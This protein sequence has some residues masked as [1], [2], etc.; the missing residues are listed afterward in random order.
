MKLAWKH[1]KF[2][3]D[4]EARGYAQGAYLLYDALRRTGGVADSMRLPADPVAHVHFCPPHMFQP[5]VG[6]A[7][8]LYSMWEGD[9]LPDEHVMALA[10]AQAR[11]VPSRYCQAVWQRHGLDS[12]VIPLG[13]HPGWHAADADRDFVWRPDRKLRFLFVGSKQQRKGWERI[14]PAW[15][16]A[17]SSASAPRAELYVKTVGDGTVT[18]AF[19]GD[20][21]ID[22][23]DLELSEMLALYESADAFI[24][25]T[26]GEGFGLPALEAMAAGCLVIAPETGGL[27]EFVS[28]QT[29]LVLER[30]T[31]VTI[32]YGAQY[33]TRIPSDAEIAIK[34][35]MAAEDW[36]TPLIQAIR[37]RGC[38]FA[39]TLTTD[40]QALK[41]RGL[42]EQLRPEPM[43]RPSR[44]IVFRLPRGEESEKTPA[45]GEPDAGGDHAE[46]LAS[47]GDPCDH[48][49]V[50]DVRS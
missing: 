40:A 1:Y 27:T 28:P 48:G 42:L 13:L 9:V 39:R 22:Q 4:G 5:F 24:F 2:P 19:G 18:T 32:A 30:D 10:L 16:R 50:N 12:H 20:V 37:R 38:E 36:S 34:L 45:L 43:Q 31:E 49:A 8:V 33:K 23:R 25:P 14:A 15:I 21:T 11:V 3:S 6:K 7:N 26:F 41:L 44:R 47:P 46:A 35:R 29:A 17:F